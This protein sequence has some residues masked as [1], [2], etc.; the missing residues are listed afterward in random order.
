MEEP[1]R[2]ETAVLEKQLSGEHPVLITLCAQLSGLRV[3]QREFTGVGFY[4]QFLV[5]DGVH[6]A[7]TLSARL[8]F[9]DVVATVG[10]LKHGA[11]FLVY[12]E[13]GVLQ[14]LEAYSYG[15]PWPEEVAD[16]ALTYFDPSRQALLE[17]L[18]AV[19]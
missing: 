7:S 17:K 19:Q 14:M 2:F 12:A 3:T 4:T 11:G 16:F 9:G 5:A 6:R 13:H 8:V 18:N 10:G 15:E 1:T